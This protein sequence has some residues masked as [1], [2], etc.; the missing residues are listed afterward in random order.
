MCITVIIRWI[1]ISC[2]SPIGDEAINDISI[3]AFA[4]ALVAWLIDWRTSIKEQH[5]NDVYR[6]MLLIPFVEATADYMQ[7]F[8][9]KS[10][11]MPPEMRSVKHNFLEWSEYYVQK[12][13]DHPKD[14]E[15]FS[16]ITAKEMLE[17]V[18][19]VHQAASEIKDNII[20]LRKENIV[21]REDMKN[22]DRIDATLFQYQILCCTGKL[23]PDNIQFVNQQLYSELSK[24]KQFSKLCT[25]QFSYDFRLTSCIKSVEQIDSVD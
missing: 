5:R 8:C 12:C 4:S 6:A 25:A 16:P 10:A 11:F 17:I 20:W 22:I 23:L 21:S 24:I 2:G 14:G 19:T 1:P 7:Q 9:F 15:N 18:D 3:G 13:K